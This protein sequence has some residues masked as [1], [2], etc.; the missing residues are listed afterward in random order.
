[1]GFHRLSQESLANIDDRRHVTF[2][3]KVEKIAF[4]VTLKMSQTS[5]V[6]DTVT[7]NDIFT[8]SWQSSFI[9]EVTLHTTGADHHYHHYQLKLQLAIQTKNIQ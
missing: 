5:E 9:N 7:V 3:F 8:I 6:L 4:L 1:L 2:N